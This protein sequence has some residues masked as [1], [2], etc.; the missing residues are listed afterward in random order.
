MSSP[1]RSPAISSARADYERVGYHVHRG[2]LAAGEVNALREHFM[3][4]RAEGPKPGDMGGDPAKGPTDPLN[5]FPRM[6]N[7]HD[8]DA[9]TDAWRKDPRL[10]AAAED[11]VGAQLAQCQTMLYFKPPGG[12]GQALHQDNQYIRKT[13]LIGCWLALDRCDEANGFMT[14]VPGSHRLGVLPVAEADVSVSFTDGGSVLPE[15]AQ[16]VGVDMEPGDVLFFHGMTIH[17]SYPNRTADHF[18]RALIVHYLGATATDLPDD[19]ATS[20][21]ALASR[22]RAAV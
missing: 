21:S 19:P 3:R 15:S 2:L 18:R 22:K 8:W 7:M 4:R 20:M 14:V 1:P 17:G 10:I 12:R 6:I 5:R 13:P 9:R 11:L 16:Q